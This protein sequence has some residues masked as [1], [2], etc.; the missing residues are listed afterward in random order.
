MG[1]KNQNA[2]GSPGLPPVWNS[3]AKCGVGTALDARSPVWF[4]IGHGVLEEVFFPEVDKPR[5]RDC[6][7]AVTDGTHFFSWEKDD[8]TSTAALLEEGVPAYRLTN[9]CQQGHYRIEKEIISHPKRAVV[10]QRIRFSPTS[11]KDLQLYAILNVHLGSAARGWLG[12]SRGVPMLFAEGDGTAIALACSLAFAKRSVGFVGKSDGWQDLSKHK[13]LTWFYDRAE[14]G[15][16]GMIGEIPLPVD[17]RELVLALGFGVDPHAAALNARAALL[18]DFET[19]TSRYCEG[20]KKFQSSTLA[21]DRNN[22]LGVNV[23]R[24]S[25]AAMRTHE[26]K[27]SPGALIASLT[28]PFGQAREGLHQEGYHLVWPRDLVQAAGGL[29]AAG[30]S[31]D[32][33]E[34]LSF[35]RSTQ[36]PDG[37]W[38]QNMWVNGEPHW[39]GIQMDETA[40][41]VLLIDLA[42][43]VGA[44][45]KEEIPRFW[46]MVKKAVIYLVRNG[47]WTPEDRWERTGGYSPFTLGA[48]IAALLIAAEQASENGDEKLA[49]FLRETADIWNASIEEWTYFKGSELAKQLGVEGYYLRLGHLTKNTDAVRIASKSEQ[50]SE[51]NAV[52]PDALALVR[53]GLRAATDPRIVNTLKVIDAV[54]KVELDYGCG[55]RR[56]LDDRY[57]EYPDGRAKDQKGGVGRAWPLFTGERGHY[58]LAAGQPKEAERMLDL[59]E[60]TAT[61]TGLIPEQTWDADD[62]PNRS[63]FRG[64][65]TT[66]ACPLVWAHAEHV[67]LLRSIRD[68]KVF[69]CPPQTLSRYG[70]GFQPPSKRIWRLNQQLQELTVGNDLQ[71]EL[72][73]SAIIRW[74]G[75]RWQDKND[76]ETAVDAI[77]LHVAI[78]PTKNISPDCAV[79]FTIQWLASG[80]ETQERFCVKIKAS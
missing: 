35:L 16:I 69:D 72:L 10:L 54:V 71:I 37:H 75:N 55:W 59:L 1:N 66:S 43:R 15:H 6:G 20:W 77:G 11:G 47:P 29:L 5:I 19:L 36:D 46:P 34:I 23:F 12:D 50:N 32:V 17:G 53:F 41:A 56:Y 60:A 25:T 26:A 18:E 28:I 39:N 62:I 73:A 27:S 79:E 64:K 49:E 13:Q 14:E 38:P 8:A 40:S 57:G 4:T 80:R 9:R 70:N 63:L 24:A 52:G 76:I 65:P 45:P 21:L 22:A 58:E 44:I 67:K 3:G 68:G 51:K 7:L 30:I 78:L 74:T 48:E 33:Y 2:P 31:D 61:D 42:R